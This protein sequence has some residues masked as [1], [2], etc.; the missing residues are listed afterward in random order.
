MESLT[1]IMNNNP[2]VHRILTTDGS[3]NDCVVALADANK[4]LQVRINELER[5]APIAR[6]ENGKRFVWG[7]TNNEIAKCLEAGTV[8]DSTMAGTSKV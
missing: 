4:K 1:E 2:V 8:A 5:I 7:Q 3:M 6:I